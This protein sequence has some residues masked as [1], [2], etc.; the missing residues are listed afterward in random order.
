MAKNKINNINICNGSISYDCNNS[1]DD[2][3]INK[4]TVLDYFAKRIKKEN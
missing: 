3:N 4:P 1:S 2:D